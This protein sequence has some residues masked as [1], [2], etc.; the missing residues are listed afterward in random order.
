MVI[1]G[2]VIGVRLYEIIKPAKILPIRRRLIEL[3]NNGL[4]S[5]IKISVEHRG[6]PSSE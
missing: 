3:I 1:C 2:M 4:F 5:L 6:C